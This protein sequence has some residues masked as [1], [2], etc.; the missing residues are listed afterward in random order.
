MTV[1]ERGWTLR[2]ATRAEVDAHYAA[3]RPAAKQ[4]PQRDLS[5]TEIT[6]LSDIE[7]EDWDRVRRQGGERGRAGDAG[8]SGG[9]GPRRVCGAVLFLRRVH[10]GQRPLRRHRNHAGRHRFPNGLRHPGERA[11]EAAQ[12]DQERGDARLDHH[13]TGGDA[14]GVPGGDLPALPVQHQ[15]RGPARFQ[16]RGAVRLQDPA[17]RRDRGGWHRQVAQTGVCQPVELPGL[18]RA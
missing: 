16:R 3:S 6:A 10:E 15:Q 4:T 18:H 1:T 5:V 8:L 12:E 9:D 17:S 2:A 7:F 14:R 11:Q 13:G